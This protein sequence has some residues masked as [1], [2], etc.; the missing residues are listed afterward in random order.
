MTKAKEIYERVLKMQP[1]HFDALHFLGVIA[2]QNGNTRNALDLIG[3]AIEI[4]PNSAAAYSN[5]GMVLQELKQFEAAVASYDKAI[6]IAPDFAGAYNNRGNALQE[7]KRFHEALASYERALQIM[8]AY[9]QAYNNRGNALKE[10]KRL[11]EALASYARALKIKPDYAEAYNN[12][13][14]TLHELMRFDE[15]LASYECAL[16]INPLSA[17]AYNN[18]GI[19]LRELRRSDEALVNFERALQIK[20]DYDE[21]HNNYGNTLGDLKRFEEALA[22]YERALKIRP[23]FAGALNNLGN[24][25]LALKRYEDALVSYE[26]ALKVKPDYEWLYGIWLHTKMT[27]VDWSNWGAQI[28]YLVENIS[29]GKKMTPPFPVLA[30][31]DAISIQR[32]AAKTWVGEKIPEK[33]ILPPIIRRRKRDSIRVGYYS[34]DYHDH[35][36]AYLMAELFECHDRRKFELTAFSFGPA[37]VDGMRRRIS[38]AFHQFLDVRAQSNQEVAELSRRMEIDIAVDLKGFTQDAR[39]EIFSFRAA[40]IQVSYLGY[41][42][43]MAAEYIDYIIADRTLIPQ[44]NWQFYSEKIVYLPNSYQVNDRKRRISDESF[45]RAELGLPATGFVFCCFNKSYKIM[46]STFDGWM[47]IL[48]RVEGSVI[49]LLEVNAT[50]ADNLRREAEARGVSAARLI[51]ARH[52]PLPEHLGRHRA[53]DLFLDTLPYNAH[54]TASDALWAGLPVLT[55]IG[56]SFAARV[57]A[58]LLNAIGVPE[59]ITAT[60]EQYEALAV[61]LATNPGRLAAIAAKLNKNRLTAPLFDTD[62]FA[63]HIENAYVQMY[64][65][66][67]AGIPADHIFVAN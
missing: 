9:D 54:T 44:E 7:I 63:R 23:D 29:R 53:A 52:M 46:P 35:A 24:M 16:K 37:K 65:S 51:F 48:K 30:L 12:R 47:R 41:P 5:R 45:S 62:L 42:G 43:T 2:Y 64:E 17:E 1:D 11:D 58:S 32:Q 18:R 49:W 6:A 66:Y 50:A 25:L 57:S 14:T 56:N 10:L 15:A 55:R 60:Q 67:Q 26:R 21:A 33:H 40:P 39:A 20:P 3:K 38:E 27:L 22:S 28:E 13:G 61:E 4:N 19:T 31:T 36:T 34:A 59:L 8:P